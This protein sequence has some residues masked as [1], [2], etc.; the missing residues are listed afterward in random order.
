MMTQSRTITEMNMDATFKELI[1]E[2]NMTE[3]LEI[4]DANAN[5]EFDSI[6]EAINAVAGTNYTGWMRATWPGASKGR[7]RNFRM[8]FP[9]LAK[10][11]N[12]QYVAAANKCI[13]ILSEDGNEFLYEDLN[14]R[15]DGT[16]EPFSNYDLIFAKDVN[17]GYK[18]RGVF[19]LDASKSSPNHYVS[20]RVATK[21]RMLGTPP[22]NVE[23]LDH[24]DR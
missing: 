21:V 9:K 3:R 23:L 14:L 12:G 5:V 4:L 17:G 19:L 1:K 11:V 7:V 8:W 20:K 22:F 16:Y 18:F 6:Y 2:D 15:D 24:I 10:K 13:N